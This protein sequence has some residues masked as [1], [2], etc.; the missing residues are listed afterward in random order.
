MA[1]LRDWRDGRATCAYR[2][3]EMSLTPPA[4]PPE[5]A[6]PAIGAAVAAVAALSMMDAAMK[7]AAL[8]IGVF[9]AT[10]LRALFA[11]VLIAPVW[12]SRRPA[13]PAWS[14]M[15]LHLARGVIS[16]LMALSFFYALTKLPIAET[17][18]ISFIAPLIAL[19][20]ARIFLGEIIRPRAIQA[21]VVGLIGTVIIVATR[22]GSVDA[23]AE[24][25]KGVIAILFSATLYA[26]NFIVIRRQS[27]AAKPLEITVFH[28]GI[29][30]VLLVP[31]VPF[32]F[33]MPDAQAA[34]SLGVA[35]LLTL[36][37]S[38][39]IAWAYARAEAQ[40]LVPFEYT[41]FV[42]AS[43]LGWLLFDE[44]IGW[45]TIGGTALIVLASIWA[46]RGE[47]KGDLPAPTMP[48][49]PVEDG[50]GQA[51]TGPD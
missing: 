45:A 37:G 21:S 7:G 15:K 6:L 14:I 51:R 25:G 27:L 10:W 20:L 30:A 33:V 12:L 46:A 17:I 26:C 32:A 44:Q 5:S 9:T 2:P 28:S 24:T 49:P 11:S 35:A 1:E 19:Y 22:L 8:A 34:F 42:W 13:W 38:M 29:S 48:A 39:G 31:A 36:A 40:V 3:S 16:L 18:A 50:A 47:A 43:I 4:P 41:G 23:D